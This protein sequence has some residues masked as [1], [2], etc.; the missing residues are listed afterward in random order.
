[1]EEERV[2]ESRV[3]RLR[4]VETVTGWVCP[5][6]RVEREREKVMKW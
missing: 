1:M 2:E 5:D 3:F 6:L 4:R